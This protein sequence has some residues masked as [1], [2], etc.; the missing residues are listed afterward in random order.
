[1]CVC[2]S[3]CIE[4]TGPAQGNRGS[5]YKTVN[6][7]C[8]YGGK[9]CYITYMWPYTQAFNKFMY[10]FACFGTCWIKVI[11]LHKLLYVDAIYSK[12]YCPTQRYI[13]PTCHLK[14]DELKCCCKR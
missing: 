11:K 13:G 3:V 12:I 9:K 14:M 5:V 6:I 1:M 10:L 8:C 2:V 4:R 7:T